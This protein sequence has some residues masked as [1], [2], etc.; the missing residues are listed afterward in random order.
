[1]AITIKNVRHEVDCL[2]ILTHGSADQWDEVARKPLTGRY[3]IDSSNGGYKLCRYVNNSGETEI[4]NYRMTARE[5]YYVVSGIVKVL[6]HN[7][8]EGL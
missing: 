1:M 4:T 3:N 5:L 7:K 2:N 8:R 6:E